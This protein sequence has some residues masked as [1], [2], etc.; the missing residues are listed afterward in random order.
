MI[1]RALATLLVAVAIAGCNRS[2]DERMAAAEGQAAHNQWPDAIES[3]RAALTARPD[4]PR[5][6]EALYKIGMI[7]YGQLKNIPTAAHTL[8]D[9][10]TKY[11]KAPEAPKALMVLGFLYAEEPSMKNIDSARVFYKLLLSNYPQSDLAAGARVELDH[12]GQSADSTLHDEARR[13]P[14]RFPLST[15]TLVRSPSARE[16]AH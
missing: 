8:A 7:E 2:V 1:R 4:G 5:A 13:D 3:Y 11:P 15:D 9:V 10:V 6:G 16:L 12:L 14:R